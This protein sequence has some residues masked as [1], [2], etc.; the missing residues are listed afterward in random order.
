MITITFSR[1]ANTASAP[2]F[3]GFGGDFHAQ[4]AD[5]YFQICR[6]MTDAGT[7]DGPAVFIDERGMACLTVKS[8]HSCAR[9]YRP[10]AAD[11]AARQER[12]E[13]RKAA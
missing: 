4:C 6:L 2:S 1:L 5:P 13:A 8:L 9:R 3:D 7:P 12:I 10:N 11:T